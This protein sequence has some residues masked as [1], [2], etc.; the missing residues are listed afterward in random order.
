MNSDCLSVLG[1]FLTLSEFVGVFSILNKNCNHL[2]LNSPFAQFLWKNR[3][4]KEFNQPAEKFPDFDIA[5]GETHLQVFKRAF[6]LYK[7]LRVLA[8]DMVKYTIRNRLEHCQDEEE[9]KNIRALNEYIAPFSE[10]GRDLNLILKSV[11]FMTLE[12]VCFHKNWLDVTEFKDIRNWNLYG[13][14][15]YKVAKLFQVYQTNF[16]DQCFETLL[17]SGPSVGILQ[18]LASKH[19][20]LELLPIMHIKG[21]PRIINQDYG[22]ICGFGNRAII[23]VPVD[24]RKHV[25]LA[26]SFQEF[27]TEH[28]KKL[29]SN[30]YMNLRG[31][32]ETYAL[33]PTDE[34]AHGSVTVTNGIR[35]TAHAYYNHLISEFDS[36][37]DPI[38]NR[39]QYVFSYQIKISDDP[40]MDE[41]T[42][43]Y[44]SK[45]V[46]R[47]W[48]IEKGADLVETVI[49][50]PGV[51]GQYPEVK[52]KMAPFI[53]ESQCPTHVFGTKMSGHFTFVY[54]EGPNKG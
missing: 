29:K 34:G 38:R 45:L 21:S 39:D 50:Q 10:E 14:N 40:E 8:K 49:N 53:Y 31:N 43:F 13:P 9:K 4:I 32:I 25:V 37:E 47:T 30:W 3:F 28:V 33:T 51:I 12:F 5:E 18:F 26:R 6:K 41:K 27:L 1:P 7:E 15:M 35:I 54:Q 36:F 44:A 16:Y 52:K 24:R 42:P 46:S 17:L 2:A 11:Q 19:R 48:R 22:N 20:Q 23:L